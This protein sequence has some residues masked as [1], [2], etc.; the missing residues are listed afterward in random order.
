MMF[1]K[2][3][4]A[5]LFG[6]SYIRAE[7]DITYTRRYGQCVRISDGQPS[8]DKEVNECYQAYQETLVEIEASCLE[9]CEELCD[10]EEACTA[11]EI[12]VKGD[13]EIDLDSY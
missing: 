7:G 10:N 12:Y 2:I 8:L 3:T 9:S 1:K 11:V 13:T 4:T 5:A 6:A